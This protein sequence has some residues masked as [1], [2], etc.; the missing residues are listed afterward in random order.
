M[1]PFCPSAVWQARC[2][3]YN[4]TAL[5]RRSP[6]GTDSGSDWPE[7]SNV[8]CRHPRALLDEPSPPLRSP[9]SYGALGRRGGGDRPCYLQPDRV[10]PLG[11]RRTDRSQLRAAFLTQEYQLKLCE[12]SHFYRLMDDVALT[13]IFRVTSGL[14]SMVL[15]GP[16]IIDYV[17]EAGRK[18]RKPARPGA[19][20]MP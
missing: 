4:G 12:W 13:H 3:Y 18:R 1:L 17:K 10:H 2:T 15:G 6:L 14:D 11:Q 8:P 5:P 7:F 19:F 16:E 9:A 20:S